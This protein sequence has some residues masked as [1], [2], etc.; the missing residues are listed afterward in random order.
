M[1]HFKMKENTIQFFDIAMIFPYVN[2]I[3]HYCLV[4]MLSF[5][6]LVIKII[7]Q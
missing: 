3:F 4:K 6:S 1:S 5:V 2:V 7:R